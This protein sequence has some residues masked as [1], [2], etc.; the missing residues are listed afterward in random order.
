MER[1]IATVFFFS[2]LI[3]PIFGT[4]VYAQELK[5]AGSGVIT[6]VDVESG[7]VAMFGDGMELVLTYY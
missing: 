6:A 2:L 3:S 1:L 5:P 7:A 4:T